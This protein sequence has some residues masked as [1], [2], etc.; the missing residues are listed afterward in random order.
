MSPTWASWLYAVKQG[1][2]TIWERWD[3]MLAD[4]SVNPGEMTSFNHYALGA[5]ADWMHRVVA[6]IAPLEPGYRRILF[7]PQPGGGLTS[8]SARHETPYGTAAISWRN[9]DGGH[10]V[11]TEVPTG[12]T[13]RVELPG[14]EPREV[15]SGRFE[16][17]VAQIS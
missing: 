8:A 13:A 5:V 14:Q 17:T 6:G 15:G 3:S 10:S 11:S 7:R 2:T 9:A 1:G 16:Y 4:G 12:A